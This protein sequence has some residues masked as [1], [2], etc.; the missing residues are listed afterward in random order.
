MQLV[1][2]I[3]TLFYES[4]DNLFLNYLTIFLQML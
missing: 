3:H 2:P 1:N 4:F